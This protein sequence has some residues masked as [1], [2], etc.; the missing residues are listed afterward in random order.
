MSSRSL[1]PTRRSSLSIMGRRTIRQPWRMY[2]SSQTCA[3]QCCAVQ[4]SGKALGTMVLQEHTQWLILTNLSDRE[5]DD[6]LDM[7]IFSSALASMQ[8]RCEARKKEDEALLF[9]LP[10]KTALQP[11]RHKTFLPAVTPGLQYKITKCAK[12][13]P[14]PS[15][16]TSRAPW[17][18]PPPARTLQCSTLN[19]VPL[20]HPGL[21]KRAQGDENKQWRHLLSSPGRDT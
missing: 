21:K 10:Q 6:I 14:T 9:C 2:R 17:S 3:I 19:S 5:R 12:A 15:A 11:L 1:Q 20:P 16:S 8:Q 18:E 4:A 7:P 13:A